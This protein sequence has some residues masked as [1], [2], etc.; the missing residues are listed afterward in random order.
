MDVATNGALRLVLVRLAFG[1]SLWVTV[2]TTRVGFQ[3]GKSP[4]LPPD[5]KWR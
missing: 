1:E 3:R 4:L 2:E 5:S